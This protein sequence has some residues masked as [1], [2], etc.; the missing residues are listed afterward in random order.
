MRRHVTPKG[1]VLLTVLTPEGKVRVA[2]RSGASGPRS[3]KLNL[4]QHITF[5]TYERPGQDMA[6]L[7]Q[8]SLEGALPGLSRPDCYPYAHLLAELVDKLWQTNDRVGEAAF[9]LISGA[10]RG[11]VRHDDPDR[12]ALTFSW[13]ILA[14]SGLFPRLGACVHTGKTEALTRFDA[15]EGGAVS[16]DVP[17]GLDVGEDTLLELALIGGSTVREA[18]EDPMDPRVREMLWLS[19]EAYTRAHVADLRTWEALRS[20]RYAQDSGRPPLAASA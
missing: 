11:L 20:A 15:L 13:K 16:K 17:R 10:F 7:T 1:D 5:Q 3:P 2:A 12:V 6:T 4:F 8:V 19:L 18:L 9:K 14:A